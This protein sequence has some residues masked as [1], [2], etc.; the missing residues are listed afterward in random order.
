[1]KRLEEWQQ[2]FLPSF[3]L[4]P[5]W[6]LIAEGFLV[7]KQLPMPGN[8]MQK[9]RV[10]EPETKGGHGWGVESSLF[11]E[12]LPFQDNR[13]EKREEEGNM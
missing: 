4:F 7:G 13:G 8:T 2:S 5:E 6:W 10:K 9:E 3:A 12:R 11:N 1:M